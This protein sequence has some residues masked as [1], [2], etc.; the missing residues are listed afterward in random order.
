MLIGKVLRIG[1]I[2]WE[3]VPVIN[4]PAPPDVSTI[5][6]AQTVPVTTV[7]SLLDRNGQA[8]ET[9]NLDTERNLSA[10]SI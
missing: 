5:D 10:I 8:D 3:K 1:F 7:E 6:D 2:G 9:A 4:A